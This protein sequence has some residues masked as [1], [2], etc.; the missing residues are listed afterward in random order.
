MDEGNEHGSTEKQKN[1]DLFFLFILILIFDQ[2][3]EIVQTEKKLNDFTWH[4]A[5]TLFDLQGAFIFL[6]AGIFASI[7]VFSVELL[8]SYWP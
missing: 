8:S 5:L 6:L 2:M 7:A 4:L 1:G 3:S